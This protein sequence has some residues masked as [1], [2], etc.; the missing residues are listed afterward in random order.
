MLNKY[1]MVLYFYVLFCLYVYIINL[2][3][4]WIGCRFVYCIDG[5]LVIGLKKLKI[6]NVYINFLVYVKFF[7]VLLN[8]NYFVI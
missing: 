6:F 7:Y 2:Y 4:I 3:V 8:I 1:E 5:D